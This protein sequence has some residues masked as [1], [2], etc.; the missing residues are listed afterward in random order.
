[1]E[2]L[3]NLRD[4]AAYLGVSTRSVRR[5]IDRRVLPF[6]KIGAAI[7]IDVEDM[8]KFLVSVRKEAL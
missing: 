6:Y 3:S 5:L 2:V 1:M 7:R 4:A 8:K